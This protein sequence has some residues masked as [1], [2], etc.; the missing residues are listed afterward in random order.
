MKMSSTA[1]PHHRKQGLTL[2]EVLAAAMIFAMVMTVLISTSSTAVHHI[3]MSARR[4]EASLLADGI[5]ADLE[6]DMKQ[7]IAPEPEEESEQDPY[8]IRILR[9]DLV[10]DLDSAGGDDTEASAISMLGAELP[11]VAKHMKRYDIEVSWIEQ[12]GSHSVKRTTF[13]FDW[14]GARTEFTALFQRPDSSSNLA[15]LLADRD[16]DP[17]DLQVSRGT[18]PSSKRKITRFNDPHYCSRGGLGQYDGHNASRNRLLC[19]ADQ[20]KLRKNN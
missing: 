4:L 6:I 16:G 11:E 18:P 15:G 10:E 2:L 1:S 12:N 20:R 13:A 3:G 17:E 5:V 8:T 7:G 9:T 14:Q 19:L